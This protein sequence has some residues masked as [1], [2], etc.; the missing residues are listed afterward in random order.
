MK[1]SY[2]V[3][4]ALLL[5]TGCS[6]Q[7]VPRAWHNAVDTAYLSKDL[8]KHPAFGAESLPAAAKRMPGKMN[9]RS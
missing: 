3:F 5:S 8:T 6:R 2:Q 1:R 4:E 9:V 7:N